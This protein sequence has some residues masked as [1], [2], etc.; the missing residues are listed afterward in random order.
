MGVGVIV[1]V[2][3]AVKV[4]VGGMV[5]VRLGS[6]LAVGTAVISCPTLVGFT[7]LAAGIVA[8]KGVTLDGD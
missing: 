1:G 8:A 3:V 7:L 6:R 4:A 5:G 2:Q